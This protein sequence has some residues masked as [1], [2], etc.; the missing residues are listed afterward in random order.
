[1][2][3]YE[4]YSTRRYRDRRPRQDYYKTLVAGPSAWSKRSYPSRYY[5]GPYRGKRTYSYNRYTNKRP[6]YNTYVRKPSVRSSSRSTTKRRTVRIYRNK[7]YKRSAIPQPPSMGCT[8]ASLYKL[9]EQNEDNVHEYSQGSTQLTLAT[10]NNQTVIND[11]VLCCADD[12]QDCFSMIPPTANGYGNLAIIISKA[13]NTSTFTN[14]D[15]QSCTIRYWVVIAQRSL[16]DNTFR[17][18]STWRI[19]VEGQQYGNQTTSPSVQM[20]F[21][22]P[23]SEPTDSM[24]FQRSWKV[25]ETD[26]FRLLPGATKDVTYNALNLPYKVYRGFDGQVSF[27]YAVRGLAMGL[28]WQIRSDPFINTTLGAQNGPYWGSINVGMMETKRV[29]FTYAAENQKYI[30]YGTNWAA[31][32]NPNNQSFV[33]PLS[34]AQSLTIPSTVIVNGTA[35]PVP[36][37]VRNTAVTVQGTGSSSAPY[38][39][40]HNV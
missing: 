31:A 19:G 3:R 14:L 37:T 26:S 15:P 22:N 11:T 4:S 13:I 28:L 39:L 16:D 8:K 21:E 6:R 20:G 1:M 10:Q 18:A 17:P 23:G 32:V 24:L 25:L 7:R 35:A 30:S 36:V 40:T 29:H 9:I 12:I 5:N 33:N 27:S 38:V 2:P 34:G